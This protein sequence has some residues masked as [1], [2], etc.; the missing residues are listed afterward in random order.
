MLSAVDRE[1]EGLRVKNGQRAKGTG[2]CSVSVGLS[3]FG[4]KRELQNS[5][6]DR[7]TIISESF[8]EVG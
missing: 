2:T 3:T 1:I 7:P 5:S 4:N 8:D 6:R